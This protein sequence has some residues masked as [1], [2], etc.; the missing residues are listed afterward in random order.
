MGEPIE[1]KGRCDKIICKGF[2][3]KDNTKKYGE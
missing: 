2:Y 1:Y 3:G